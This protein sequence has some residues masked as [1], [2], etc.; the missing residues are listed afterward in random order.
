LGDFHP[1]SGQYTPNQFTAVGDDLFF[2]AQLS[3]PVQLW[4]TGSHSGSLLGLNKFSTS[5]LTAAADQLFFTTADTE[6]GK[7]LWRSDGTV[8]GTRLVR[9]INPGPADSDLS[10]SAGDGRLLFGACAAERCRLWESDGSESG[11]R[12]LAELPAGGGN[13]VVAGDLIFLVGG[14]LAHGAELWAAPLQRSPCFGDCDSD[15][16]VSVAELVRMVGIALGEINA[17][18][19]SY[20]SVN[21]EQLVTAVRNALAGC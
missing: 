2:V 4:V 8:D 6:Y 16:V 10:L 15:G 5:Q 17:N 20:A 9:D 1:V 19:C 21:I 14:E 13:F 3:L 11:T 12:P 18:T 7:E